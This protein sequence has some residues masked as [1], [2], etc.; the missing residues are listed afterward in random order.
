MPT[1]TTDQLVRPKAR[2]A[3]PVP[4]RRRYDAP[5]AE[6]EARLYFAKVMAATDAALAAAR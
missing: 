3:A 4:A 6:L 2:R 1:L 5:T